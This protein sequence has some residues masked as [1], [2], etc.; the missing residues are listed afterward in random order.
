MGFGAALLRELRDADEL[1]GAERRVVRV[2]A[3]D[4]VRVRVR[5]SPKPKPNPNLSGVWLAHSC[6]KPTEPSGSLPG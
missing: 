3:R 4:R 6:S 5:V 1:V 2:R